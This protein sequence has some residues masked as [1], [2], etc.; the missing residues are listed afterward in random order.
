M[1][2]QLSIGVDFGTTNT[3]V[4]IAQPGE[5]VRAVMF[6]DE[7]ETSDIYRSV[8][9]ADRS[10]SREGLDCD[11]STAV[12]PTRKPSGRAIPP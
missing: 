3:V 9:L 6:H 4:A 1:P 8:L 5:A 10:T 11:E 12:D 7:R 2:K